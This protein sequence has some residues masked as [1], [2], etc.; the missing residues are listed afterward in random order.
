MNPFR[1]HSPYEPLIILEKYHFL[2]TRKNGRF[3]SMFILCGVFFSDL[4]MQELKSQAVS[5]SQTLFIVAPEH[6]RKRALLALIL[7]PF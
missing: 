5:A 4:F 2:M 6:T 3:K 7:I 1:A